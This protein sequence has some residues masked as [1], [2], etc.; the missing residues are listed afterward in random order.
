MIVLDNY[1]PW[2]ALA[3]GSL[4]TVSREEAEQFFAWFMAARADRLKILAQW[5]PATTR[6]DA[7]AVGSV[8]LGMLRE[9]SYA[10][11]QDQRAAAVTAFVGDVGIWLGERIIAAAPVLTWRLMTSHKKATGYQRPVLMGFPRLDPAYYVDV[12]FF[13]ASWAELAA[14]G[15]MA[16]GE[17]LASVEASALAD[18]SLT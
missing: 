15:R 12:G 10:A 18:A 16:R 7:A 17:F 14:R 2:P 13:V 11:Y 6:A 5:V 8:V 1:S 3:K 4:R 9:A